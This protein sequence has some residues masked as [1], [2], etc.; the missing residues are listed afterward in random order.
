MFKGERAEGVEAVALYPQV[1][2]GQADTAIASLGDPVQRRRRIAVMRG[3]KAQ[4]ASRVALPARIT[5]LQCQ[6]MCVLVGG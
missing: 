3:H 5:Q 6:G 1:G 4:P 2:V